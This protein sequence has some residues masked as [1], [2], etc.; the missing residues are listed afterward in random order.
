VYFCSVDIAVF[1]EMKMT[2]WISV[3]DSLPPEGVEVLVYLLSGK[4]KQVVRDK[5]YGG[6]KEP[7][8]AG[9]ENAPNQFI[10]HWANPLKRPA[11]GAWNCGPDDA[12]WNK[13]SKK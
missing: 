1:K 6:W 7:S 2:E 12:P 13:E 10:T 8:C 9:W 5:R 11:D 4:I 3:K